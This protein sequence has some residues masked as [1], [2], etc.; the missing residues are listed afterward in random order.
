VTSSL[1]KLLLGLTSAAI[2][3]V[4]LSGLVASLAVRL[5]AAEDR[6]ATQTR[7]RGS[8]GAPLLLNTLIIGDLANAEQILRSL[9]SDRLWRSVRLYE[10]DGRTLILD[11]S[12]EPP[13][14][15]WAPGWLYASLGLLLPEVRVPIEAPPVVYGILGVALSTEDLEAEVRQE[16]TVAGLVALA[17][18]VALLALINALLGWG[19]R[20]IRALAESA[21]RVGAGDLSARLPETRLAEIAPTVRAFNAMA[22][23]LGTVVGELRTKEAA[24]RRLAAI[25]EQTEEAILTVDCQ[26][27]VTSLNPAATRLF[28]LPEAAMLGRP[29]E[30]VFGPG[31]A[32]AR[33]QIDQ[34]VGVS[35]VRRVEI[36]LHRGDGP[37]RVVAASASPL[38][39]ESGVAAGFIVVARDVTERRHAE[40]ELQRAKETAEAAS[41]A[42]AEFL[43][44]MSH[45]IRTPVNGVVGMTELLLETELTEQQRECANLVKMSGEALLQVIND[46]LDFSKIEAGRIELEAVDFDVRRTI[47]RTLKPLAFRASE[48]EVELVCAVAPETPVTLVGDPGRLGQVL[49]NL[50]GNAVKFTDR[51]EIAVHV[52]PGAVEDD[53]M[54][55]HVAVRDTGIGVPAD[56]RE[57]IFEPFVQAD[58]STTRRYGGT[59]LGLA[60][61]RRLVAVMGGRIW[62]ES[63]EGCGST[64]HFTVRLRRSPRS[65]PGDFLTDPGDL[66]GLPVLIVD[67]NAASRRVLADM[68]SCWRLRP[69]VADGAEAAWA[70]LR[71][72]LGD[73]DLPA[74]IIADQ[75]MPG[76]DGF[77]FARRVRADQRLARIP[78]VMVSSSALPADFSRARDEGIR[79][80]HT[81]PLTPSE[82]L[83]AIVSVQGTES[84]VPRRPALA[85]PPPP[86]VPHPHG[87][88]VL[89]AEDNPVNQ[90]VV[91]RRLEGWGHR[92]LIVDN[93]RAAVQALEA[94]RFDLV[95]MD[96]QMPEMDGLAATAVIRAREADIEAGRAQ[97]PPG[98]SFAAHRAAGGRIP[99]IALTAHA[100]KETEARCRAAGM[101][102]YLAK[103]IR[104]EWLRE[105]IAR[106]GGTAV[107][108]EP[109][110]ARVPFDVAAALRA[111]D[112]E[113]DL[114]AELTALFADDC[115]HR[116]AALRE[117]VAARDGA[118]TAEAAHAVKGAVATLGAEAAREIAGRLEAAGRE[119][120]WDEAPG[121]LARLEAEVAHVIA[122]LR[123][124]DGGVDPSAEAATAHPP[125]AASAGAKPLPRQVV[126]RRAFR[127]VVVEDI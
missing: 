108:V 30:G 123:A 97:A 36:P 84:P 28:G 65:V 117:A 81:K 106:V 57:V 77:A 61:T 121:L 3:L 24:N 42:K 33:P 68:V 78:I 51:G 114:L 102:G 62:V 20:P 40:R 126:S 115:P 4:T 58:S 41:R 119:A 110:P 79:A 124:V 50:V 87:L 53:A 98:S 96:L 88:R 101:D 52:A 89:L 70:L 55:L 103:P 90:K 2:V 92:V 48:K 54:E 12:P 10:A 13:A 21:A 23:N 27:Q 86:A 85:M 105:T 64:F 43:A 118:L 38:H 60:I 17:L 111:V 72:G 80:Y 95:L 125:G 91:A 59:G 93:G 116:L 66:D 83:D 47:G 107:E 71:D 26:L 94:M 120:R 109:A 39:D 25:V 73:G 113:R 104:T 49:V 31:A 112:G 7:A 100:L 99:I 35:P 63:E 14:S 74:V 8:A 56:K 37:P 1:R 34:L 11:A 122:V 46:V 44:T 69:R 76:V 82:L 22:A 15:S 45:E 75:L 19:L 5:S 9:N 67:D 6:L 32:E 16:A 127:H 18:V 29:V